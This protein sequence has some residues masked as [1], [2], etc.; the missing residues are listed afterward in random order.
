MQKILIIDDNPTHRLIN[1]RWIEMLRPGMFTVVEATGA[2]TGIEAIVRESPA[3]VLLDFIMLG[4]DGFQA[5][6]RMKQDIPDCPP[7]IFLTCA[8]TED[9]KRNALALGAVSCFDKATLSGE[10]LLDAI[11]SAIGKDAA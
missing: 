11:V 7:V 4:D 2:A 6:H 10:E 9:L 3:C 5:L 1:R 8:L